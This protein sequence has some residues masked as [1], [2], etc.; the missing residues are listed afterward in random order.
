MP[1]SR[2]PLDDSV[3]SRQ[4]PD[5]PP[6]PNPGGAV[7][8]Q[9]TR[10]SRSRCRLGATRAGHRSCTEPVLEHSDQLDRG[11]LMIRRVL[12]VATVVVAL[13]VSS[14]EAVSIQ[15]IIDLKRAGLGEEVLLALVEVDG[16]V[17]NID[18]ATLTKLKQAGVSEKVIRSDRSQR[19]DAFDRGAASRSGDA[20]RTAA[21]A[22]RRHR[23]RAANRAAGGG[24]C[25]RAVCAFHR[26]QGSPSRAGSYG[27]L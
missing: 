14:A 22:S 5:K 12:A 24:A 26:R 21:A 10:I 7:S 19:T 6:K 11:F 4:D 17:F 8:R 13:G 9:Q 2:T 18:T 1:A 15:D 3:S 25:V 23:T 20:A 16:G 27:A